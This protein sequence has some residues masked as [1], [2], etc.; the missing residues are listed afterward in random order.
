[1]V[2]LVLPLTIFMIIVPIVMKVTLTWKL[3]F[4]MAFAQGTI[5][6]MICWWIAVTNAICITSQRL[7]D[8]FRVS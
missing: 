4:F 2:L 7:V 1:M 3:V 8:D 6:F 5:M